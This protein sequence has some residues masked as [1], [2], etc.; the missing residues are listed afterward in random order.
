MEHYDLAVVGAGPAGLSA[1][2][3]AAGAGMGVVVFDEN[4]KPGGQLFKQIHKFFGSKEHKAKTRGF[5]IGRELL[6]EARAVGVKAELNSAVVAVYGNRELAVSQG[7]KI[8]RVKSDAI[9]IATGASENMTP[10]EGWTLPGVIGAGA[11]QTLMNLHG[12][13]PG[14][15]VLML[16]SGNVGLVVSY[17]LLQAGCQVVAVADIARTIGGYGVHASKI[18]RCGVP[19]YLSHTIIKAQGDGKVEN[20]IIGETDAKRE[21]IPGTERCFE[22]DTVCVAVGLSPMSQLLGQAG[23]R[24]VNEPQKGGFVP[25]VNEYGETD[26][27]GIYAAGDVSG[28]EEASAAMIE[29]RI[30]GAAAANAAGFM[31]DGEFKARFEECETSLAQLR[32]GMFAPGRKGAEQ[33]ETDEGIPLS[34]AL[35]SKGYIDENE[36]SAFPGFRDCSALSETYPVIE[37]TQNIP[38]NPCQDV[39][40]KGCIHVGN[41]IT[42]LPVL[43]PKASCSACGMCVAACSGQAIFL[44][45]PHYEPGYALVTIPYEFFPLPQK[46]DKGTALSR[47]GEALC[48]A[49]VVDVRDAKALDNTRLLSIKVPSSHLNRARFFVKGDFANG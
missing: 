49:Q 41:D 15:R 8:K 45:Q 5:Q 48:P 44:V 6:E 16:G 43:N 11:A 42:A 22:A 38:C 4:A 46:G 24:M 21:L 12:V 47:S 23:C 13:M 19:F 34:R 32:R 18:A 26:I 27:K 9:I 17:Q 2:I 37:C 31:P 7:E 1:A 35:L 39:C 10:F 3:E 14:K 36:L 40:P 20:V 33:S 25:K 30:S 28:I 29:G